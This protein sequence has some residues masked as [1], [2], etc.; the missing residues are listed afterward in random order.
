MAPILEMG[1]V[2]TSP[3]SLE[4]K[5]RTKLHTRPASSSPMLP[6]ITCRNGLTT[7]TNI[8]WTLTGPYGQQLLSRD[9]SQLS[10]LQVQRP[11]CSLY[12]SD[13]FLTWG[14]CAQVILGWLYRGRGSL[15]LVPACHQMMWPRNQELQAATPEVKCLV[16]RMCW[17]SQ[18]GLQALPH[19]NKV[20]RGSGAT[21][22]PFLVHSIL[23]SL[24]Q[25]LGLPTILLEQYFLRSAPWKSVFGEGR[26]GC[27]LGHLPC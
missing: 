18:G 12:H 11:G 10:R 23:M 5:G 14:I 24:G 15:N 6:T 26:T 1:K 13:T 3:G 20:F 25:D 7:S 9:I 19:A 27:D 8:L 2:S 4:Y 21:L 22:P 17:Y 16:Q